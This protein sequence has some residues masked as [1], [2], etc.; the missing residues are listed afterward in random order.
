MR[1]CITH[2]MCVAMKNELGVAKNR[3]ERGDLWNAYVKG[4]AQIEELKAEIDRLRERKDGAYLERNKC[5]VLIAKMAIALGFKSGKALHDPHDK[6]WEDDWRSVVYI[7]L[8]SGQISWHFHDSNKDL[9]SDLP[10]YE[11]LWDGHS[12]DLKY[13]RVLT[14]WRLNKIENSNA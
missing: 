12:T 3:T 4:C 1:E 10:P 5:V 2:H 8:P 7:D 13:Q 9:L 11:G 14:P 6:N